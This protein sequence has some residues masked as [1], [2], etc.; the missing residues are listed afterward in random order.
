MADNKIIRIEESYSPEGKV[1]HR[2]ITKTIS[3]V[4]IQIANENRVIEDNVDDNDETNLGSLDQFINGID[5]GF[6]LFNKFFD[7]FR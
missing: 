4:Q 3:P 5:I 2:A 1:T 7:R 6:D